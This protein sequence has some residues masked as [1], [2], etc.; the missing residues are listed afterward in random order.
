M[1]IRECF[2]IA[3]HCM[4]AGRLRTVLTML[5]IVISVSIVIAVAGLSSGLNSS[6]KLSYDTLFQSVGVTRSM[7]APTLGGNGPRSLSDDD[8]AALTKEYDPSI[9][10]GIVPM[11]SSPTM[12][13]VGDKNYLANVNGANA[14]YLRLKLLQVTDGRVFTNRQYRDRARVVLIGPALVGALFNG[15]PAAALGATVRIARIS[16]EVIGV[17]NGDGTGDATALMPLTTARTFLFGGMHTVQAIGVLPVDI[18]ALVPALHQI[19]EIM[20]RRHFIKEP[21][22][23]DFTVSSSE[24]FVGNVDQLLAILL[25]FTVGITGV[26]LFISALGLANIMLITVTERTCEIGVRRAVGAR[27][28]AILRQFLIEAVL[29]AGVGGMS[30]VGIG[31]G[32]TL[33]ERALLPRI[34]P[35]Y[36]VPVISVQAILLAFGLS[37][38]VGLVAGAYPAIRASRMHPWDALRH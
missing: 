3:L 23:R 22:Q 34:A 35:L 32:L 38:L 24:Q 28:G 9:I 31:I 4:Y 37:L 14:D 7:A 13:F 19:N 10:S 20:D 15:D 2:R 33:A 25:W 18:N 1:H 16:F 21:D 5:G 12:M 8:V 11:V 27:R 6:Y 17:L 30:G 29:I 36:G 26:A